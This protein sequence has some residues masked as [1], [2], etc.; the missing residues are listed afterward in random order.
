LLSKSLLF[1]LPQK[2]S[3]DRLAKIREVFL[4][5]KL[6]KLNAWEEIFIHKIAD[7]RRKELHYLN[8]DAFYWTMMSEYKILK[9]KKLDFGSFIFQQISSKE[10]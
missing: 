3:D 7:C 10:V 5:I 2:C 9:N 4:R 1:H 6:I 8:I